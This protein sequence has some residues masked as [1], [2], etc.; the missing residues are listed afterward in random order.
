[1][2]PVTSTAQVTGMSEQGSAIDRRRA[3]TMLAVGATASVMGRLSAGSQAVCAVTQAENQ[4]AK[5]ANGVDE[6]EAVTAAIAPEKLSLG[7]WSLHR[8][9]GA[10]TL[11]PLDFPAYSKDTFGFLA[12]EYVNSFYRSLVSRPGFGEELRRRCDDIGVRSVLIL[13]DGEGEIAAPE[14]TARQKAVDNHHRWVDLAKLLGCHSIRVNIRGTGERDAQTRDAVAGLRLMD[15]IGV[16]SGIAIL[17]EN[18]GGLSSDGEWL[19]GVMREVG[20]TNVGTMV[21]FKNFDIAPG[22]RYD[23]Y[24]GVQEL[25]PFARGI[26]AKSHDFDAQGEEAGVSYARVMQIVRAAKFTGFVEVEYE[27]SRLGEV[28]GIKVTRDLLLRNGCT[29]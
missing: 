22:N 12:V 29:L 3:I 13:C 23:Y 15:K 26:S 25:M 14:G 17:V 19:A 8:A 6:A 18:H 28:E 20:S 10:G 7:Q 5:G 24:K 16:E 21:D 27:G 4:M 1:M 9:L 2:M 11:D